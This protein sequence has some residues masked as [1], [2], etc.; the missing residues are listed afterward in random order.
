MTIWKDKLKSELCILVDYS[1]Q[2]GF[3]N[4]LTIDQKVF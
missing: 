1:Y 4:I 3:F 2:S